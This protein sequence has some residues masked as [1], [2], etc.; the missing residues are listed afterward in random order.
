MVFVQPVIAVKKEEL[1]VRAFLQGPVASL[2]PRLHSPMAASPTCRTRRLHEAGSRRLRQIAFRKVRASGLG[3]LLEKPQANHFGLASIDLDPVVCGNLGA[4]LGR[5]H[6][7]RFALHH[8]VVD[9]IFNKRALVLLPGEKAA[10]W[11]VSFSGESSGTSLSHERMNSPSNGCVAAPTCLAGC[12]GICL[13]FG[14]LGVRLDSAIHDAQLLRN[15][16]VG[17]I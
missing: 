4:L 5:V 11:F 17:N 9:A 1:F 8:A 7:P 12:P 6:Y 2:W 14:F 16:I 13:R 15:H 10:P 3:E